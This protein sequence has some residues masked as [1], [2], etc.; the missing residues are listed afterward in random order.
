MTCEKCDDIHIAQR[1][2]KTNDECKCDCHNTISP[3]PF[4]PP[5]PYPH[6]DP[7]PCCP[8][9]PQPYIGDPFWQWQPQ[10]G[11]YYTT[12]TGDTNNC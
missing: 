10:F 4:N 11:P 5:C 3:N 12:T 8:P 7:Y 6:Y 9:W 1:A 2:G